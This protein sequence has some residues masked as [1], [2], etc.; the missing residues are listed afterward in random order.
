MEYPESLSK[1]AHQ[2]NDLFHNEN[3]HLVEVKVGSGS[4][5][6][7]IRLL[8]DLEE[9]F[10]TIDDCTM[11]SRKVNDI[12]EVNNCFPNGYRLELSSP[13]LSHKLQERWEFR[14]H[15]DR[16][17]RVHYLNHGQS[18][19]VEGTLLEITADHLIVENDHKHIS[20]AFK[21]VSH[22]KSIIDWQRSRSQKVKK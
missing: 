14:K 9:R 15:L 12:L 19:E 10:V 21:D 20:I 3:I 1:I 5:A 11:L 4:R 17:I 8:V 13:G 2:L 16:K 7:L 22:A 18:E 6:P